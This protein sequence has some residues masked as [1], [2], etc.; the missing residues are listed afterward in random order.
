M[1]SHRPY[2]AARG[3]DEAFAELEHGRGVIYD[4]DAV[5]ACLYLYQEPGFAR[6]WL[7]TSPINSV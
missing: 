5:D 1:A 3:I 2:R 4:V 7:E 6:D